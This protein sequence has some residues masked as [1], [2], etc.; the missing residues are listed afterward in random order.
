MLG[1]ALYIG[2]SGVALSDNFKEAAQNQTFSSSDEIV[3]QTFSLEKLEEFKLRER[4]VFIDFTAAWC[5][6]CQVNERTTFHHP[7]VV[8]AFVDK[9]VIP[10]KA[11]WTKRDPVITR[12]LARFGRSGVPFYVLFPGPEKREPIILP[13]FITPGIVLEA[14]EK[15]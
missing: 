4:P 15:I 3:W 8:R 11:D 14:L 2:F 6:S 1:Y 13:E 10:L 5:L 12:M 9:E 7:D